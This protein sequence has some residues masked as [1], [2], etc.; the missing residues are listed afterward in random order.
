MSHRRDAQSY[1]ATFNHFTF[2]FFRFSFSAFYLN[3]VQ[4][5]LDQNSTMPA[6]YR[7]LPV[8]CPKCKKLVAKCNLARHKKSCDSGTLSCPKCPTFYTKK[9][10]D[11]NYHLAKHHAPKDIK[12][13][14]LCTVCLEEFPIF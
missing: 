8:K 9:K 5:I 12:L 13:S 1:I 10:E 6:L 4:F 11:L 2:C 7:N 14:T 3:F